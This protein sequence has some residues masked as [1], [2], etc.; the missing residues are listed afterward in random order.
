MRRR[1]FIALLGCA[2]VAWP[3]DVRAQPSKVPSST[4]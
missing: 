3:L 4:M 2:A 1:Q